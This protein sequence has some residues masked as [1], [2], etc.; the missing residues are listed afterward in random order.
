MSN[1]LQNSEHN[2]SLDELDEEENHALPP[3]DHKD[4]EG[5]P[6]PQVVR[7]GGEDGDA[8][9]TMSQRQRLSADMQ[10]GSLVRRGRGEISV[11][12]KPED[13]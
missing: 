3:L 13:V 6:P 5:V 9:G 10:E 1:L 12:C 7:C 11:L 2:R 4:T 8:G